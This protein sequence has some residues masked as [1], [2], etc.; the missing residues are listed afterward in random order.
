LKS[1]LD[2][3]QSS[4]TE[5]VSELER[6]GLAKTKEE[7]CTA[8]RLSND[9]HMWRKIEIKSAMLIAALKGNI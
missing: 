3:N 2:V 8:L 6:Q 1:T 4:G 7:T 9:R 5:V